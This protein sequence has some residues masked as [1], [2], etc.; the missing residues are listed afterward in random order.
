[1][2]ETTTVVVKD[3]EPTTNGWKKITFED[4]TDASTKSQAVADAAF[5]ARGSEVE[6]VIGTVVNGK[7][8]NR[9]LNE[10][11]GVSDGGGP[12]RGSGSA[13]KEA[14]PSGGGRSAGEQNTIGNQWAVGRA[15]ELLIGSGVEF[16]F[17]LTGEVE[18]QLAEL[19][20]KLRTMRDLLG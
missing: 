6:A 16:E 8:T 5:A 7:Y 11:A 18:S 14:A 13:R 19:A 15:V 10:I 1:M 2:A 17:P 20:G 12:R 4:G 9:Y 3:V